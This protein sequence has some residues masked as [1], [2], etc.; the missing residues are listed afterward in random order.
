MTEWRI[1]YADGSTF[2][3]NDGP[4]Q[5]APNFGAQVVLVRD[6]HVGRR[7]LKLADYYVWRPSLDRWT[8][9]EDSASAILAMAREPWAVLICG[10]YLNDDD[11]ERI[12]I[13]AHNDPDLPPIARDKPPHPAWGE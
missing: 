9:H 3:S 2:S 6:K 1:Y 11:F 10:Q 12:L 5:N 4:A 13:A 7:V 8:D